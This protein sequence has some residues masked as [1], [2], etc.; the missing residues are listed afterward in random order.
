MFLT[1]R[2]VNANTKIQM[3]PTRDSANPY[4]GL[5]FKLEV[6]FFFFIFISAIAQEKDINISHRV[7]SC[8]VFFNILTGGEV[9]PADIREGVPGLPEER[10]IHLQHTHGQKGQGSE[11]GASPR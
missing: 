1:V 9:R 4:V 8:R 10:R 6:T 3:D 2:G 5:A 11:A 7:V